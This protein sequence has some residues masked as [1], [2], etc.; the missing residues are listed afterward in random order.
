MTMTS[1]GALVDSSFKPSCCWNAWK[2]LGFPLSG[3]CC[4]GPK[5][6][7][8]NF[9]AGTQ[10][11]QLSFDSASVDR[12]RI[13]GDRLT[14]LIDRETLSCEFTVRSCVDLKHNAQLSSRG[15]QS[16]LP[17]ARKVLSEQRRR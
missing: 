12:D 11:I 15:V 4:G 2:M 5:V 17:R 8:W 3:N 10:R 1:A 13:H 16:A 6:A 7:H 9:V 14:T